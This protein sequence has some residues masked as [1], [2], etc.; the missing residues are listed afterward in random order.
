MFSNF[1]FQRRTSYLA[2]VCS[3]IVLAII[4]GLVGV[5]NSLHGAII[6]SLG[7]LVGLKVKQRPVVLG[8]SVFFLVSSLAMLV[9]GDMVV[10]FVLGWLLASASHWLLARQIG[11]RG[12]VLAMVLGPVALVGGAIP[13][14]LLVNNIALPSV[15]VQETVDSL[16][17]TLITNHIVDP[18]AIAS[19]SYFGSV[20][21]HI[22]TDSSGYLRSLKHYFNL[23]DDCRKKGI[24]ACEAAVADYENSF[25]QARAPFDGTIRHVIVGS[26]DGRS[27]DYT[28][29]MTPEGF[30]NVEVT[31]FHLRVLEP[32]LA[33]FVAQ[34]RS[35]FLDSSYT[36]IFGSPR[37]GRT[38]NVKSGDL[39]GWGVDDV[40]INVSA[41]AKPYFLI[42]TDGCDRGLARWILKFNPACTK[43]T[44]LVSYFDVLTEP[45]AADW[46][47]WGITS[48]ADVI[49]T[50]S[51]MSR[52]YFMTAGGTS[53]FVA[54]SEQNI[55]KSV[56]ALTSREVVADSTFQLADGEAL[57][58]A[59]L[60]AGEVQ[61]V[62]GD[63]SGIAGCNC[64]VRLDRAPGEDANGDLSPVALLRDLP[65]T[66]LKI[67]AGAPFV[68]GVV[69]SNNL[70]QVERVL[71]GVF[72]P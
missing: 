62:N 50:E 10:A 68:A 41:I 42:G 51:E 9:N 64:A 46:K 66:T 3:A 71:G 31:L 45:L 69:S 22:F 33:D 61:I 48:A 18:S 72:S 44:K 30:D 24:D 57:L 8:S 16:K 15:D 38:M 40:S 5:P 58:V 39:L 55:R 43:Q 17:G 19:V 47:S 49:L 53:Y 12:S 67:R 37:F 1:V 65:K 70:T 29:V 21:G 27:E 36:V 54:V 35:P 14:S 32:E 13:L 23:K 20:E 11:Q 28:I 6:G 26:T 56:A 34:T 52:D 63:S 2:L 4:L 59:M 7:F 25:P 60:A